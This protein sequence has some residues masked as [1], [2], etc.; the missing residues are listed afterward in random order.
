MLYRLDLWY[1]SFGRGRLANFKTHVSLE[2]FFTANLAAICDTE[3][4]FTATY[5]KS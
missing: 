1:T 2:V 4:I 3:G 5:E